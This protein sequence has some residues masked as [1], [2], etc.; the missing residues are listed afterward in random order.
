MGDEDPGS[1]P[2]VCTA[3]ILSPEPSLQLPHNIFKSRRVPETKKKNEF[4]VK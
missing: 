2:H 3:N 4:K 1:G